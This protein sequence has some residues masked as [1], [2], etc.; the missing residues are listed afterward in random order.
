M[1]AADITTAI[2]G[3]ASLV[4]RRCLHML[5]CRMRRVLPPTGYWVETRLEGLRGQGPSFSTQAFYRLVR[6]E[7]QE[8]LDIRPRVDRLIDRLRAE[9]GTPV[10]A[11]TLAVEMYGRCTSAS[12]NSLRSLVSRARKVL[13][14]DTIGRVD[15]EAGRSG[16]ASY[17]WNDPP[18]QK[19]AS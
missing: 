4:N 1:T 2:Y 10:P 18:S 11:N 14:P 8:P 5:I 13:P 15:F 3:D 7:S 12:R 6:D 9:P 19:E 16:L 17:L